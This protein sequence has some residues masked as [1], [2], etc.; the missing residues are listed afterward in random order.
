MLFYYYSF[1]CVIINI[2]QKQIR[3]SRKRNAN[4]SFVFKR[5]VSHRR[6]KMREKEMEKEGIR[7]G[8]GEGSKEGGIIFKTQKG[9]KIK[10][11]KK[12]RISNENLISFATLKRFCCCL[13]I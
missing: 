1:N 6:E 7:E 9:V 11:H 3:K 5:K 2:L 8:K 4:L 13:A 10:S 12:L